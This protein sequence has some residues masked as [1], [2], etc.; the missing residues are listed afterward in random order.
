MKC[1]MFQLFPLPMGAGVICEGPLLKLSDLF[2]TSA[3][4][5]LRKFNCNLKG[6]KFSIAQL[7]LNKVTPEIVDFE[8][9]GEIDICEHHKNLMTHKHKSLRQ[10]TCA[11]VNCNRLGDT[12]RHRVTLEVSESVYKVSGFHVLVGSVL[13][14]R[15]RKDISSNLVIG[16]PP[17]PSVSS[18]VIPSVSTCIVQDVSKAVP[19]CSVQQVSPVVTSA[20]QAVL[21]VSTNTGGYMYSGKVASAPTIAVPTASISSFPIISTALGCSSPTLSSCYTST[22]TVC[23]TSPSCTVCPLSQ[24]STTPFAT[25]CTLQSVSSYSAPTISTKPI[26]SSFTV[27][28]VTTLTTTTASAYMVPSVTSCAVSTVL[29]PILSTS[30]V[31]GVSTKRS[32]YWEALE[33]FPKVS[34][35]DSETSSLSNSQQMLSQGSTFSTTSEAEAEARIEQFNKLVSSLAMLD[36]ALG[37]SL[38]QPLDL[39]V[40]ERTLQRY[41]QLNYY[42]CK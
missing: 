22:L 24:C 6:V 15:H 27:P 1:T 2:K 20:T 30:T 12:D 25:A 4:D 8:K 18:P 37:E 14:A 36:P 34:R 28:N 10:K 23:S 7:I 17:Q 3:V 41:L 13:C 9:T 38:S 16:E 40:K 5:L 33:R 26:A 21:S 39:C 35:S 11:I 29:V 32:S 31:G 42:Y 19:T